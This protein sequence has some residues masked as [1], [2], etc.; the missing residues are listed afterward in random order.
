MPRTKANPKDIADQL[1]AQAI[2]DVESALDS[3]DAILAC[4]LSAGVVRNVVAAQKELVRGL[5]SLKA[6]LAVALV[7]AEEAGS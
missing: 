1:H 3:I 4:E 5:G 7:E 2:P 6:S